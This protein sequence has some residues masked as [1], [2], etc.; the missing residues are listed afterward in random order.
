NGVVV[1]SPVSI[2]PALGGTPVAGV[3]SLLETV[4]DP[5]DQS[6]VARVAL[7]DADEQL[8]PGTFVTAKV[9]VGE[10]TVPLAVKRIGIQ[11]FRD[12]RVIYAQVGDIYE[13]RMLN[14]G[15]KAGEWVEVLGGLDPGTRYVTSNSHLL[16]ADIEKS[17]AVH[18]H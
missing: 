18:N 13:V 17:G 7:E 2:T 3:V 14:L 11:T 15:R 16:K 9:K 8:L 12:F 4:A 10:Y 6:V 1:G 5:H